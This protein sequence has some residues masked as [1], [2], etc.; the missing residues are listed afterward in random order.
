M[1]APLL[2]KSVETLRQTHWMLLVSNAL[3]D[4]FAMNDNVLR[5][6]DADA[7]LSALHSDD[8]HSD[9]VTDNHR[10]TYPSRQYQHGR[11]LALIRSIQTWRSDSG[12]D[13]VPVAGIVGM[14]QCR[15]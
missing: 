12:G 7:Y 6:I 11:S 14:S 13:D 2:M 9:V 1:G 5:R 3:E 10:L 4:F 15:Y 8:G